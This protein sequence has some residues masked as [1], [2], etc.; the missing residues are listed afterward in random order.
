MNER[1]FLK[2]WLPV[3]LW[4]G[5]IFWMSSDTFS[6]SNTSR[7]IEPILRYLRPHIS[8]AHVQLIQGIIRKLAHV[9][10]YFVLSSLLFRAFRSGSKDFKTLRWILYSMITTALVASLDEYHQSFVVSRTASI[11]DVGIDT[12][13]GFMA[14]Y[15]IL[16]RNRINGIDS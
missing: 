9:S 4:V 2:Y 1:N 3:I 5:V 10:I 8:K 12:L 11:I 13:G 7:I 16:L 6:S 14:Q 15:A